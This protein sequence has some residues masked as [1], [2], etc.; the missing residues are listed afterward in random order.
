[1]KLLNILLAQFLLSKQSEYL[2]FV[3]NLFP[4]ILFLRIEF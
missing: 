4:K 2:S 3:S 1:M